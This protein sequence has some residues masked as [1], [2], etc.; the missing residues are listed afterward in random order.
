[1]SAYPLPVHLR[2]PEN[3]ACAAAALAELERC[4]A[5]GMRL[6]AARIEAA[7]AAASAR[8]VQLGL[9]AVDPGDVEWERMRAGRRRR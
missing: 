2:T 9:P 4:L 3:D 6:R 7:K 1:M 8:R 5:A